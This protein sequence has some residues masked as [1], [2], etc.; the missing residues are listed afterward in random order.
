[1]KIQKSI[2]SALL[3]LSFCASAATFAEGRF[4]R[5][6]PRRAEVLGRD[7]NLRQDIRSE[8]G[9]LHG[10][11]GNLM[12]QDR[13]IQRQE[14]RDARM[15][16]GHITGQEERRLNREQNRLHREIRRDQH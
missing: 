14:R 4:E 9:N 8:H 11:A 3:L 2:V 10:Q 12:A 7:R 6:H 1:V 5:N 16:G 13:R 15:N